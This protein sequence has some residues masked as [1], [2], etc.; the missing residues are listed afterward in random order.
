MGYLLNLW[1]RWPDIRTGL[2]G[3]CLCR[4]QLNR[5][6]IN[7]IMRKWRIERVEK[8]TKTKA[9]NNL[10]PEQK[11]ET[12]ATTHVTS[13]IQSR[14]RITV[15]LWS[16]YSRRALALRLFTIRTTKLCNSDI[17]TTKYIFTWFCRPAL[18]VLLGLFHSWCLFVD[19]PRSTRVVFQFQR[20]CKSE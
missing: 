13:L 19:Q 3:L 7:S 11:R 18:S 20:I 4:V 15:F 10:D 2:F 8:I 9:K 14:D 12:R 17:R 6:S 5:F 16:F 1:S